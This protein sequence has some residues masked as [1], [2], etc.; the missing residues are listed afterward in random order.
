MTEIMQDTYYV[1]HYMFTKP[2]NHVKFYLK[3]TTKERKHVYYMIPKK[4]N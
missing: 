4:S 1:G 2:R 3:P